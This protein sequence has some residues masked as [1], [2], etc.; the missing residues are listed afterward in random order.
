MKDWKKGYYLEGI[1]RLIELYKK[2][3][4]GKKQKIRCKRKKKARK[5]K[6]K[7]ERRK[8]FHCERK[9]HLRHQ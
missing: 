1:N 8:M 7:I 3:S 5:K 6:K 4:S 9:E 2:K